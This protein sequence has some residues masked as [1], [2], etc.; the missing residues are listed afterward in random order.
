MASDSP[1]GPLSPSVGMERRWLSSSEPG[2][3]RSSRGAHALL[4]DLRM[5]LLL[6]SWL[7]W[8]LS[9]PCDFSAITGELFSTLIQN[10]HKSDTV[11]AAFGPGSERGRGQN[12]YSPVSGARFA[13]SGSLA[14]PPKPKSLLQCRQM[15][16]SPW[17]GVGDQGQMWHR[18]SPG[19]IRPPVDSIRW[20]E[21]GIESKEIELVD[22]PSQGKV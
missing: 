5:S 13:I 3:I 16:L 2:G 14:H 7:P 10:T 21:M 12:A 22:T 20:T 8:R 17:R 19:H 4:V 18:P 9:D 11:S 6:F 1:E 15:V